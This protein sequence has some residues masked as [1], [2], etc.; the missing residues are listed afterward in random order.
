LGCEVFSR[1]IAAN[2]TT[3][4]PGRQEQPHRADL[5]ERARRGRHGLV[6]MTLTSLSRN[7]IQLASVTHDSI[8]RPR[9]S[10]DKIET[11]G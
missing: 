10:L 6:T 7:V 2:L 3:F 11:L 8:R 9:F 5:S 4:L 1:R